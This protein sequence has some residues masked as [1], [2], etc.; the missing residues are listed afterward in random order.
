MIDKL[1]YAFVVI[2]R[3]EICVS[4]VRKAITAIQE[5]AECVI[6]VVCLEVCL[7]EKEMANKVLAADTRSYH[8][9]KVTLEILQQESVCG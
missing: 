6:M 4:V 2:I 3:K 8:Y 9:G 5:M 7:G 1:A